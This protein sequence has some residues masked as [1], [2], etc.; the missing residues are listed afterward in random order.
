MSRQWPKPGAYL[1]DDNGSIFR[2]GIVPKNRW[3]I[4][5][6]RWRKEGLLAVRGIRWT[7]KNKTHRSEASV[8]EWSDRGAILTAGLIGVFIPHSGVADRPPSLLKPTP[9]LHN[10]SNSK[11]ESPSNPYFNQR[12]EGFIYFYLNT[13]SQGGATY[14][15]SELN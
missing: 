2:L 1:R 14:Y 10:Q 7:K 4:I 8:R 12:G 5:K 3:V 9:F 6:I 15:H 11:K 13:P